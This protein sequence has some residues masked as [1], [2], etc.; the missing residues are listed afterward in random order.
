MMR[1]VQRVYLYT[2]ALISLLVWLLSLINAGAG[3]IALALVG[4]GFSLN[5]LMGSS[6]VLWLGSA[7][8]AMAVWGLHWYLANREARHLTIAGGAERGSPAR[9]GYLWMGQ[10][11][12][13]ACL[14][15]EAGLA[16]YYGFLWILTAQTALW[17]PQAA[18][19][20]VGFLISLAFWFFLRR[21]TVWDGDIGAE[22]GAGRGWRRAYYYLGTGLAALVATLGAGEFLRT[23]LS[24]AARVYIFGTG[25]G[26]L[27]NWRALAAASLAMTIV[28]LPM[29]ISLWLRADR[30]IAGTSVTADVVDEVNA[31]SRKLLLYAAMMVG[32]ALTLVTFGYL[33][34]H[35]LLVALG[36]PVANAQVLWE[37][38]L[39]P[40]VAYLPEGLLLWLAFSNIARGDIDWTDE[41]QDAAI[42]RRLY[43]YVIAALGLAA[44]WY[45]L[46]ALLV[47]AILLAAGLWPVTMLV[48]PQA[49]DYFSLSAALLLA[50]VP[51]WWGHW[52]PAQELARQPGLAGYA[53]RSSV[54]RKVYLY[55]VVLAAAVVSVI[56]LGFVLVGA[57]GWLFGPTAATSLAISLVQLGGGIV[58][59][60]IFWLTHALVLRADGRLRSEDERV[61]G[62][63]PATDHL[64]EDTLAGSTPEG[65]LLPGAG[66]EVSLRAGG[67]AALGESRPIAAVTVQNDA[68][69]GATA[70]DRSSAG[71]GA[72]TT[73]G[74]SDIGAVAAGAGTQPGEPLVAGQLPS[75]TARPAA[76]SRGPAE[77]EGEQ[78]A[79]PLRRRSFSIVVVVD[80][81]DGSLGAALLTAL[82][83]AFPDLVLWP[84]ALSAAAH[85]EMQRSLGERGPTR[86]LAEGLARARIIVGPSD[87]LSP[88]GLHGEVAAG[89][90]LAIADSPARKVLLPPRNP[91]LRW[92]GAPDWPRERWVANAVSE[93][94]GVLAVEPAE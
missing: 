86:G 44:F 2:V 42:L 48:N 22:P 94:G 14:A 5:E 37:E 41:S 40:A 31:V 16:L 72:A 81:E 74:A 59:A 56:T 18:G 82:R 13:L 36:Q 20:A 60:L 43:Y 10:F 53:E 80:G 83:Q 93:V 58:I 49:R 38:T 90:A 21:L 63:W 55:A 66:A 33:V 29:T 3:L 35:G 26:E 12:A 11:G 9:K 23:F 45:G 8:V 52:R 77:P 84:V 47:L 27:A 89:I 61:L 88:G 78:A 76:V 46:Q 51:A 62:F 4:S 67:L 25:T 91:G 68:L 28:A 70:A 19:G 32:T 6:I 73:Q 79:A 54:L 15:V 87:M 34:W 75:I 39:V 85:V 92:A 64:G 7:L 65:Q 57:P 24:V 50:G 1:R 17:I 71:F 30:L 69:T